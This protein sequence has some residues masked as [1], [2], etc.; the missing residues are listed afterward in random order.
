[1]DHKTFLIL[2][3]N[4]L[5]H[6]A[7]HAIP[8]L[9]TK[10]G[11]V[12]NAVYGF[13]NVIEKMLSVYNPDFM[14]VAWD[15]PGGTF[16][17]E[18]YEPYKA[19]REKKA[20]ELYAQIPMIQ[21]VLTAYGV[22]SLTAKGFEADDILGTVAK[23]NGQEDGIETLIVTGDLDSLQLVDEKTKVVFFIKGLSE[24][25][26]YDSAAVKERYGL[27]PKRLI[28]YKALLGDTSD[29]LKGVPGI[30]EKSALE[31]LNAYG[32]VD[33][34]VEAL[35]AG[36][37]P[38][39]YAKKFAGQE[40]NIILMKRLVTVVQDVSL[41]EFSYQS[42]SRKKVDVEK[43]LPMLRDYEFKTLLKKYEKSNADRAV[44]VGSYADPNK[45]VVPK[46]RKAKIGSLSV[47]TKLS[48]LD[49]KKIGII[50]DE[51]KQDLFGGSIAAIF[52][53]DGSHVWKTLDADKA[54]LLKVL[55]VLKSADT[56]VGHDLKAMMHAFERAG[57]NACEAIRLKT[58]IDTM[59]A[60]YI[61]APGG[62]ELAFTEVLNENLGLSLSES[63]ALEDVVSYL[64]PLSTKLVDQ[65]KKDEMLKLY[66]E[67]EMPL[68]P[69]LCAME[70]RGI[71]VDQK[72]LEDLSEAFA[73]TID[74]LTKKILKLAGR[75]F[76]VNSP[77][78]L[79]DILFVD[80]GLPTKG[81]KKTKSG[82]STAA[83][84][85]EKLEEEHEIIPLIEEYREVA[86]LKSTYSD[87]LPQLVAKDG[88]I[89]ST[90]SQTVA[91]TGRL[92]SRDPNLQN[93]PIRTELGREIRNAFVA[94]KGNVLMSADY[95]QI[96]LRLAA[97][98]SRDD[99]FLQAFRD[100][101][102][103]HKRTAAEIYDIEEDK[104]TKEQREAA[105]AI[106]FSILYGV[107]PRALARRTHMSFEEAKTFIAK[108]FSVHPGIAEF[109]DASK[110][111][112]RVD[113]Y[114]ETMFGRRRYLPDIQSG[115]PQLVAAAE[116]MAMNMPVQGTNADIIKLAMIKIDEWL[117]K[118]GLEAKMVLQIHDEL[119]FEVPE[120]E[121]KELEKEIPGLMTSVVSLD[122]PLVVDVGTG[123]R[124]GE[125][126]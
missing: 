37:L 120:G 116:R 1:M 43:L 3:G 42:T 82:F 78:Q 119:V 113:G 7:W 106:N 93:I 71:S 14:A 12:V 44:G 117:R 48:D 25:K 123:K 40:K 51:K 87:S 28:D 58:M 47:V 108:Y 64:L 16:R 86:K 66:E 111:K 75:E 90:F 19:Q 101:A 57:V 33:G 81:I 34:I 38:D 69:V 68:L 62:R 27:E 76:N 89:H 125:I 126:E 26:I 6:R 92:S 61:L 5:L 29:N 115:M 79:A 9:T 46:G 4:A 105:K 104:V 2:D 52:L 91:A 103:V 109:I 122:V 24:V 98:M 60:A 85:L 112:A 10:D 41:P 18:E 114:V 35:K 83:P 56:I 77:S 23:L 36:T 97:V 96:E 80:L 99:S 11:R 107:G 31:L 20:D 39:K 59:V 118:S 70:T 95:S 73:K 30:G 53:T 8:P 102:D 15:L 55:D 121:V 50:L 72:K 13:T 45:V 124:W 67:I 63:P 65:L 21:E 17:H 32:T 74:K 94:D 54:M 22:P 110:M 100:G 88:R 49:L 84:E